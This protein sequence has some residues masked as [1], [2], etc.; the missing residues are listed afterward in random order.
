MPPNVLVEV[1]REAETTLQGLLD[2][3]GI[4][5][6]HRVAVGNA[7]EAV[8]QVAREMGADLIVI[9][10]SGR[11]RLA[12][13]VLGSTAEQVCHTAPCSVLAVRA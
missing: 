3:H 10:T 7:S 4:N 6:E 9:G 5:G 11:S 12:R 8:V 1:R 2:L 13:L